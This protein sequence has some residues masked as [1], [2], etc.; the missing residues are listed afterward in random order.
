MKAG[1]GNLR[2]RPDNGGREQTLKQN[3]IKKR[4]IFELG[5]TLMWECQRGQTKVKTT[6]KR[7]T[8]TLGKKV[9]EGG[10]KNSNKRRIM[11]PVTIRGS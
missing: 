11:A 1:R 5:I 6:L 3:I 4:E 8:K 9:V 2:K 10:K 7:K